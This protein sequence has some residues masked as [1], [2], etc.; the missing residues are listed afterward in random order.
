MAT[1]DRPA[2]SSEGDSE[3]PPV[4]AD[5]DSPEIGSDQTDASA[6]DMEQ[7]RSEVHRRFELVPAIGTRWRWYD[8]PYRILRWLGSSW[9]HR[10]MPWRLRIRLNNCANFLMAFDHYERL[11]VDSLD[12]PM[13]NLIVPP[14]EKVTQGALWIVEFFP[15]SYYANLLKALKKNGWDQLLIPSFDGPN[16]AKVTQAR[17]GHGFS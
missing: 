14:N 3:E 17:R 10:L 5:T 11:K 4:E 15:P 1:Q 12:N 16:A 9:R 6:I 7:I 2:T 13:D 8:V